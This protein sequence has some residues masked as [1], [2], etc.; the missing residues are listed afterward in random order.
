MG[1]VFHVGQPDVEGFEQAVLGRSPGHQ[2]TAPV[3]GLYH[4]PYRRTKAKRADMPQSCLV[5]GLADQLRK[6]AGGAGGI[7]GDDVNLVFFQ[8]P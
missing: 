1:P 6:N 7:Q 2:T 4:I 5:P 8:G 3:Q